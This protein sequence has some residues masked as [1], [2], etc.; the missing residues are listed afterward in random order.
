MADTDDEKSVDLQT[1][2]EL[3]A[4]FDSNKIVGGYSSPPIRS[5]SESR[6]KQ[7]S[8]ESTIGGSRGGGCACNSAGEESLPRLILSVGEW[9]VQ[10][11]QPVSHSQQGVSGL[12]FCK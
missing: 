7:W 10:R 3:D 6:R 1:K 12:V 9:A 2:E 5:P 4:D 8:R 11:K